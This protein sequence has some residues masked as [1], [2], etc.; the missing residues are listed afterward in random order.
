[1]QSQYN[2]TTQ[3]QY[4]PTTQKQYNPTTQKQLPH[5]KK[6][7]I[8]ARLTCTSLK[9]VRFASGLTP[10]VGGCWVGAATMGGGGGTSEQVPMGCPA[11]ALAVAGTLT[12]CV[13]VWGGVCVC[14][15]VLMC[16]CK[17]YVRINACDVQENMNS[18]T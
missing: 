12:T 18:A 2:P 13:G 10:P 3:K 4:N 15:C 8:S 7:S 6:S 16:V 9:E 1:M 14:A 11:C 17:M 5:L